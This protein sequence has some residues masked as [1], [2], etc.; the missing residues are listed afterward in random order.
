MSK[1]IRNMSDLQAA[2][3][4]ACEQAIENSAITVMYK[5]QDYIDKQY[6][7]DPRFYPNVYERTNEF[8]NHVVY[9]MLSSN[10]AQIY[11]DIEG[12]H[13]KND[14]SPWQVVKWASESKHGADYYKTDTENFWNAFIEWCNNNLIELLKMNLRKQGIQIK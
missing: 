10:K 6:Y 3:D 14:F 12:M 2:I 8:F 5:L 9:D 1:I 7:K 11:V 4:S 13:Y